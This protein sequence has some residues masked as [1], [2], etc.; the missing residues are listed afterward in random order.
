MSINYIGILSNISLKSHLISPTK[1]VNY[2]LAFFLLCAII[3]VTSKR[4]SLPII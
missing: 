1:S 3:T 2:T 4:S